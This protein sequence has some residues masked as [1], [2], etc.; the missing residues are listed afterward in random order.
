MVGLLVIVA[1]VIDMGATR[2]LRRDARTATDA[3][4]TAGVVA[5]GT[6]GANACMDAFAYTFK[7]LGTQTTS[8]QTSTACAPLASTCSNTTPRTPATLTLNGVTVRVTNPVL[9]SSPLMEGTSLGSGVP[10]NPSTLDGE[11][12]ERVGVEVTRAQ[13]AFFRGVLGGSSGTYTV[14]SVARF[15][16]WIKN[17]TIPP[18]LVALNQH[19]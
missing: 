8:P 12:C 14:H 13:P 10:Q 7:D 6:P 11:A 16:R 3:G 19:T 17:P 4:A 2:S 15:N 9:D 1:L 5:M 18:A